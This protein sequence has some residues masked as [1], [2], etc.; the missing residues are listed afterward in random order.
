VDVVTGFS[1]DTPLALILAMRPDVL[2]KGGD[3]GL[4]DIVGGAEVRSWG[5]RVLSIAFEHE[6]ST[7]ETLARIRNAR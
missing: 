7:T 4:E 3:W 1:D 6:R 2:V 5:G